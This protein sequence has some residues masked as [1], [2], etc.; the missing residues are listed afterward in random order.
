MSED[1]QKKKKSED[2]VQRLLPKYNSPTYLR[3]KL[4]V[5]AKNAEDL[6]AKGVE[7]EN[8]LISKM[9]GLWN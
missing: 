8:V 4:K 1:I 6:I 3:L 9:F 7:T 2:S 5:A